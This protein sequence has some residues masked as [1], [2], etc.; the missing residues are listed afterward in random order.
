MKAKTIKQITENGVYKGI[1]L[2]R[3]HN[4]RE[5]FDGPSVS[6]SALKYMLPPHG[7]SQKKFWGY[8][9]CNPDHVE[10]KT[11]PPLD[12]GRAAHCLLL[13]DEVFSEKFVLRPERIDG[14]NWQGNRTVCKEW[15]EEQKVK[16]LTVVTEEQIERI[17]LMSEDAAQYPLI[18]DAG[19]LNGKVEQTIAARDPKTGI[20]L[21]VRPDNEP[22]FLTGV[23]ADLKTT[24]S[25]DEEFLQRQLFDS[26]YYLQGAMTRTVCD[27][28]NKPFESFVFVYSLNDDVPDT[29]HVELSQF[30][31]DRGERAIRWCLDQIRHG[32]DTGDWPGT[33]PFKD[34]TLPIQSKP[35]SADR[36]DN[37]LNEQD[38]LNKPALEAAE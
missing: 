22:A 26:G 17:R 16:G 13:G 21:K 10:P 29:A 4:D 23:Y 32:L 27:L 1:S 28:L 30:E 37:F 12:F 34:G 5:L 7:G 36:L 35:W 9:K 11:T 2:E 3:Y 24:S 20:W 19:L 38:H 31:L 33:R 14:K 8:W 25:M 6:K 18:R 15:L